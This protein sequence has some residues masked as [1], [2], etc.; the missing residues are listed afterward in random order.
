[1]PLPI[2]TVT[3][4][5]FYIKGIFDAEELLHNLRVEGEVS[6]FSV[7]SDNAYFTLK[8]TNA[9][10]GCCCFCVSKT[11]IPKNGDKIVV[12][13]RPDFYVK[14]GRLSFLVDKIELKGIGSLFAEFLELKERLE[15][16][17]VFSNEKKIPLPPLVKNLCVVTSHQGAVIQDILSTISKTTDKM[18][19]TVIDA[20]VQGI[21]AVESIVN[22]LTL[23]DEASFDAI[24]LA[25]GG[26]SFEDLMPFNTEAVA[27]AVAS[28]Q[29]PIISAVG[30]ETDYSLSDFSADVRALTPTAA[31][32][33]VTEGW[34]R[35]QREYSETKNRLIIA[36]GAIL[37]RSEETV[38]YYKERITNAVERCVE[39]KENEYLFLKNRLASL[40]P[41]SVLKNGF[42]AAEK[43]GKRIFRLSECEKEDSLTLYFSDGFAE[44]RIEKKELFR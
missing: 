1:M 31:A 26:G 14:S 23:A 44:V 37:K 27:R 21:G 7:K 10:I 40:N 22:A 11:F 32:E 6:G 16:E 35:L 24:V 25:R 4:L 39:R 2:I 36:I 29:T 3:Q 17:G 9:Q 5:D 12:S 13:G 38:A 8:D 42:I 33:L 41:E 19:I 30:H 20:R 34:K 15:R 28:V 18:N 43:N